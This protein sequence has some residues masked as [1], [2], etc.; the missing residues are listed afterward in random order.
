MRHGLCSPPHD[1]TSHGSL[2]IDARDERVALRP[3]SR[4]AQRA[5]TTP[6]PLLLLQ[7]QRIP[8]PTLGGAV[9]ESRAQAHICMHWLWRR[10]VRA[11]RA[12]CLGPPCRRYER[13]NS[14]PDR[15]G[16]VAP[17]A[18]LRPTRALHVALGPPKRPVHARSLERSDARL[19]PHG[20]SSRGSIQQPRHIIARRVRVAPQVHRA[21]ERSSASTQHRFR[22]LTCESRSVTSGKPQ[23]V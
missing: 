12:C 1:N 21:E 3:A 6:L 14:R 19:G 13:L 11:C 2:H 4:D 17:A 8:A 20:P 10:P 16:H 22:D 7:Q 18:V 23:L 15:A 9:C 5:C